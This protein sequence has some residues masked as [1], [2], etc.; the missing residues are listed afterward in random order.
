M[1]SNK[2]DVGALQAL[3]DGLRKWHEAAYD[4]P[5]AKRAKPGT[6]DDMLKDLKPGDV[7]VLEPGVYRENAVMPK[8]VEGTAKDPIVILGKDGVKVTGLI[9]VDRDNVYAYGLVPS[10]K[11]RV[12]AGGLALQIP[13]ELQ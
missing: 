2:P 1:A 7:L 6:L 3:M 11:G 9:H 10:G 4:Y 8:K 13:V 12:R 5:Q